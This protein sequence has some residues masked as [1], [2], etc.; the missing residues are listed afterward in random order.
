[1]NELQTM[2][3]RHRG[4]RL[5]IANEL[6]IQPSAV[7]GWK[8]VPAERVL[9]VD[10]GG[11]AALAL[12]L[13]DVH[14]I[15]LGAQFLAVDLGLHR[16]AHGGQVEQHMG[17]HIVQRRAALAACPLRDP[18]VPVYTNVHAGP[19]RSAAEIPG[20]LV[21][22]LT[23]RRDWAFLAAALFALHPVHAEAVCWISCRKDLLGTYA[24][25]MMA[26]V[27]AASSAV[28]KILCG[29]FVRV[30]ILVILVC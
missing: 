9:D 6:D 1:M 12:G 28:L 15:H 7:R 27:F 30:I 22:Q 13:G 19:V 14:G 18:R 2:L 10:E 29:L 3:A 25:D 8:K 17:R 16:P 4:L 5:R 23:A 24:V 21:R 26:M 11:E 20:L